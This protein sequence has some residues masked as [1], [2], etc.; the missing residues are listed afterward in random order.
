M[1]CFLRVQTSDGTG[2]YRRTRDGLDLMMNH[3][4]TSYEQTLHI[5]PY[6]DRLLIK[7]GYNEFYTL[8]HPNLWFGFKDNDQL[9]RWLFLEE[10]RKSLHEHGFK[11]YVF[12]NPTHMVIGD[13]QAV[14]VIDRLKF[15][16]CYTLLEV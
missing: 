15:D 9:K 4:G 16:A 5:V 7:N 6:A 13:T 2:L 12:E 10:A 1:S 14:A 8:H 11:I 3:F